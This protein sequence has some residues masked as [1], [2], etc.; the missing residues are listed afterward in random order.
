MDEY[1]SRE[2]LLKAVEKM[3][4]LDEETK[5]KYEYDKEGY[6]LLI[7]NAPASNVEEAKHGHWEEI[8][9][10]EN[11]YDYCFKCSNC[12]NET[13]PNSFVVSPDYCPNCGAKMDLEE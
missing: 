12:N 13:P 10:G 4:R 11:L 2:T 8:K 9:T 3:D 5:T 7:Q 6:I 1:I